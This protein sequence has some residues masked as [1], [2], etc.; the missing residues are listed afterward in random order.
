MTR[1]TL[2][3]GIA[4]TRSPTPRL[5]ALVMG[6]LG[7]ALLLPPLFGGLSSS[8]QRALLVTLIT[9]VLSMVALSLIGKSASLAR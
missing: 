8:G 4:L 3:S 6:A 5:P 2:D 7:L 1:T 9:I